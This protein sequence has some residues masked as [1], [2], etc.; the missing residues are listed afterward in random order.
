M[1]HHEANLVA[2][3][4]SDTVTR[5][6]REMYEAIASAPLGD[7]VFGE[8]PTVRELEAQAMAL[9]GKEAALLLP[10]GTMGNLV[11]VTQHCA[12]V[13]SAEAIVGDKQHTYLWE[14]G[15][16]ARFAGV[17]SWVLPNQPDG[18]LRLDDVEAAVR[19]VDPHAPTSR[20]LVLENTH[21]SCGGKPLPAAYMDAAG[22]L[23]R[24]KGLRLHVDGARIFN[25]AAALNEPVARL[26]RSADSV[27]FCLSKGLGAPAG[28]VLVGDKAFIAGARHVR[29]ALGGGMRQAG[30]IAA[31]GLVALRHVVP[32][33][34]EDHAAARMLAEGIAGM[35]GI[36]LV[37]SSVKTNIVFFD[38][39]GGR[40]QDLQAALKQ[41]GVKVGAYNSRR[42]RAVTHYDVPIA[43]I[44]KV[45]DIFRRALKDIFPGE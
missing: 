10:T 31:C 19:S 41:R 34:A 2:D 42:V 35:P 32:R 20:L 22:A 26:C 28:S 37:P 6:T 12:G 21:N 23:A 18:T 11:A 15:N 25:A 44:P 9:L 40:G 45:L 5:P 14:G 38:V 17:S 1:V 39:E 30:V 29:K 4:R 7:D 3:L 13:F 43:T 33:L 16:V 27:T 8:D 36:Q 24:R